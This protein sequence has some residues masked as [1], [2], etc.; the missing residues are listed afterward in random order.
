[1]GLKSEVATPSGRPFTPR[2]A[3]LCALSGLLFVFSLVGCNTSP[4][5]S[6]GR[7]GEKPDRKVFIPVDGRLSRCA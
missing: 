3:V 1:M 6:V 7:D 4:A 5:R 2:G